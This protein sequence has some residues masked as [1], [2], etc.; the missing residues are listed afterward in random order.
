VDVQLMNMHQTKGRELDGVILVFEEDEFHA[1]RPE[2][3]P[4]RKQARL[5][6]VFVSRARRR[7]SVILPPHPDRVI[8]PFERIGSPIEIVPLLTHCLTQHQID[9][10]IL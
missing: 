5:R 3:Q 2:T 4:F 10:I 8:A 7:I 9:R 1:R 6:Y